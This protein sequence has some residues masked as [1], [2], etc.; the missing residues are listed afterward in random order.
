MVVVIKT[1]NR[2]HQSFIHCSV[3]MLVVSID[4]APNSSCPLNVEELVVDAPCGI[5]LL[6][7]K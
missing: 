3:D 1:I 4:F 5:P 7:L 6:D 2:P